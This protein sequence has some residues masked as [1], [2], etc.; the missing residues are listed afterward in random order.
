MVEL[1]ELLNK[2]PVHSLR[3]ELFKYLEPAAKPLYR[4][5]MLLAIASLPWCRGTFVLRFLMSL[6]PQF[7]SWDTVWNPELERAIKKIETEY[8]SDAERHRQTTLFIKKITG[9]CTRVR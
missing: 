4:R 1:I 7:I 5:S 9:P 6:P 8:R 3:N 2:R